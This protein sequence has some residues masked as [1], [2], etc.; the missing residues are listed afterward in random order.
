MTWA[1]G[2]L[3]RDESAKAA[4]VFQRA[5][6][7]KAVPPNDPS[8]FYYLAGALELSGRTQDALAAIHKAIE[9]A[10]AS[11]QGGEAVG[12]SKESKQVAEKPQGSKDAVDKIRGNDEDE[13]GLRLA[14]FESRVGWILFHAKRY[15]EADQAY[16]GLLKKYDADRGSAEVRDIM[17]D[18]RF[19]LSSVAT[20]KKDSAAAEEWLEQVL[21][22]FPED[23]SASNDLG[24]LWAERGNNLDRAY[25]MI[26]TAVEQEPDNVAYRDSLGWVLFRLGR[27]QEALPEMEKAAKEDDPTVFEHLGDVYRALKQETK[28]KEAYQKAIAGFEKAN[29]RE[30]R[31]QLKK[32][33]GEGR[34]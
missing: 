26:R 32:K 10:S 2:L 1:M 15:D 22:E 23:A 25:R 5:I 6:D 21:D 29:E 14:R 18:A 4:A 11:E 34:P 17:R 16:R 24:Y 19:V 27:F 28:A 33:L 8:L 9:M 7:R 30:K 31:D 13:P 12:P 3:S 20:E